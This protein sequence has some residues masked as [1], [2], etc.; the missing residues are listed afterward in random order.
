MVSVICAFFCEKAKLP[1]L[2]KVY[3]GPRHGLGWQILIGTTEETKWPI[4][5]MENLWNNKRVRMNEGENKMEKNRDLVTCHYGVR[6]ANHAPY[7][8]WVRLHLFLLSFSSS[9]IHFLGA[10]SLLFR[11][12][13]RQDFLYYQ[14]FPLKRLAILSQFDAHPFHPGEGKNST[15]C[16]RISNIKYK[17]DPK[18]LRSLGRI[19]KRF[20][21]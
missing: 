12:S 4:Q 17:V 15:R 11:L 20:V 3:E 5:R 9:P 7:R 16:S 18:I 1:P 13:S 10:F 21:H 2:L 14:L 8:D 19:S 6:L